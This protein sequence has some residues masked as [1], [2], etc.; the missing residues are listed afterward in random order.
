MNDITHAKCGTPLTWA[1]RQMDGN[2]EPVSVPWCPTCK[3]APDRVEWSN[4][5]AVPAGA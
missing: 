3:T 4:P 1:R 2:P 5:R